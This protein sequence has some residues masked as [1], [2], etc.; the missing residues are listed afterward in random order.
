MVFKFSCEVVGLRDYLKDPAEV[1][2]RFNSP[3]AAAV[4]LSKK[5]SDGREPP[6]NAVCVATTTAEIEDE[7][8]AAEIQAALSTPLDGRWANFKGVHASRI[9]LLLA[10]IDRVF[11]PLITLTES[12]VSILRWRS[13]LSEGPADPLRHRS[14]HLSHD[15]ESWL[16]ISMARSATITFGL[17]A[18]PI[19]PSPE[20]EQRIVGLVSE[21][22]EEPLGHQLFREAWNQR[23][24]HPRSALVIGVAAAEVGLK[25]LIGTLVPQAQWL[26]DEI[27]TPS[28]GKMLRKYLPSLP[29]KGKLLGK[30]IA[31]PNNL[32][33]KLERA[34]E[35]R[36]KLVH[37]GQAP[38]DRE[39]LEEMLRAVLDLLWIC[40]VY[41]G[42]IWAA[43]YISHDTVVAWENEQVPV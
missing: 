14:E 39:E 21:R 3:I 27:Q 15:G 40:D 28:L 17:P 30:K 38:P 11:G 5:H 19:E 6:A 2:F 4:H 35:Y 13:G 22:S 18:T 29:I 23:G 1:E 24:V 16:E 20:F 9:P 26:V 7:R 43:E 12:T 25:K 42:Q 31:P 41:V 37:A 36:N 8:C 34:V 33:K 10:V 32:I